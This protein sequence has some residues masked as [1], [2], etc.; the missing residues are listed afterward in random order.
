MSCFDFPTWPHYKHED[1]TER[2]WRLLSQI[3]FK[4]TSSLSYIQSLWQTKSKTNCDQQCNSAHFIKK[5]L[6]SNNIIKTLYII[7]DRLM[8]FHFLLTTLH[9][10]PYSDLNSI[11]GDHDLK[12]KVL[13]LDRTLKKLAMSVFQQ[14]LFLLSIIMSTSQN[15]PSLPMV[16]NSPSA[17]DQWPADTEWAHPS[18]TPWLWAVCACQP[19]SVD[20]T[21]ETEPHGHF[22]SCPDLQTR[23]DWSSADC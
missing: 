21:R 20:R 12:S 11:L 14:T 1:H 4:Y 8:L 5:F 3:I 16:L 19:Y 9:C 22:R 23:S 6:S 13:E 15:T 2:T 7:S 17:Q 18:R 10:Q